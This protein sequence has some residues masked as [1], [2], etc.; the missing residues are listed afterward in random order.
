MKDKI[1]T[2]ID[3]QINVCKDELVKHKTKFME[4]Q[5]ISSRELK[6]ICIGQIN[7]LLQIKNKIKNHYKKEREKDHV[8]YS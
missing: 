6:L 3:D 1:L 7:A 8:S 5:C 2:I 4:E